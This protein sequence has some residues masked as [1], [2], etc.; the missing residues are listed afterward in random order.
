MPAKTSPCRSTRLE[1]YAETHPGAHLKTEA[2]YVMQNDPGAKSIAASKPASPATSSAPPSPDG[3]AMTSSTPSPSN[4]ANVISS[5]AAPS[6]PWG[7]HSRRRSPNPQRYHLP[8]FRFQ[9][10]RKRQ[11]RANCT[12]NRPWNASTFQAQPEAE[13]KRSH[14]AG[15]FTTVTRLVTSDFSPSKKFASPKASK[16]PSPTISPSSG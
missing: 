8:R 2:W 7:R 14:T 13:Q 12:S 5:P 10:P 4:Q 16:K 3:S 15:F 11:A 9:P 1:K 6:T